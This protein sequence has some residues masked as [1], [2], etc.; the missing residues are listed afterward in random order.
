MVLAWMMP[1]PNETMYVPG[2]Y[3]KPGVKHRLLQATL[4][5]DGFNHGTRLASD[6]PRQPAS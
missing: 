5:K 1:H 2:E 4:W 3:G 6:P